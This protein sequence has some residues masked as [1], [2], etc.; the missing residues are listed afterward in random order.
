MFKSYIFGAKILLKLASFGTVGAA[1]VIIYLQVTGAN[2]LTAIQKTVEAN[3]KSATS[4]VVKVVAEARPESKELVSVDWGPIVTNIKYGYRI[5]VADIKS[6]Q[7]QYVNYDYKIL[8][9]EEKAKLVFDHSFNGYAQFN[10]ELTKIVKIG[11]N[12]FQVILPPL[13]IVLSPVVTKPSYGGDLNFYQGLNQDGTTKSL[14][15]SASNQFTQDCAIRNFLNNSFDSLVEKSSL[16]AE[17]YYQDTINSVVAGIKADNKA[18]ITIVRSAPPKSVSI[19]TTDVTPNRVLDVASTRVITQEQEQE[20]IKRYFKN[21][22]DIKV[23]TKYQG[24]VDQA[25]VNLQIQPKP[26]ESK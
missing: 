13:E 16:E 20:N 7:M 9:Y 15:L 26:K 6:V 14:T 11:A 21:A 22:N 4:N 17:R 3:L 5:K 24:L 25:D 8:T 18:V 1:I 2:P 19:I 23:G 10:P 12:E